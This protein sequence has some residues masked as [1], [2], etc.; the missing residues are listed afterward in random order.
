MIKV[1][2]ADLEAAV[3]YLRKD[4]SVVDISVREEPGKLVL[5]GFDTDDRAVVFELF[6]PEGSGNRKPHLT[7]TEVFNVPER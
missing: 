5:T 2:L 4:S 6:N 3:S 7:K 1:S